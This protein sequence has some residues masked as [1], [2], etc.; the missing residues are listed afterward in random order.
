MFIIKKL[1]SAVLYI[2]KTLCFAV[3]GMLS[4]PNTIKKVGI[5]LSCSGALWIISDVFSLHMAHKPILGWLLRWI[6]IPLSLLL[7]IFRHGEVITR[8]KIKRFFEQKGFRG[9]DRKIPKYI[10]TTIL[11]RYLVKIRFKSRIPFDKWEHIVSDLEVFYKKRILKIKN[12]QE[13]MTDM[14]IY[15]IEENLPDFIEW[16]DSFMVDGRK[17]AIGEGYEGKAVWDAASLAHGICAGATG[18]GKTALLRCI[19]HQ[20]IKKKYNVTVFDFKGGGDFTESEREYQKYKDLEKGYGSF[21]ISEPKEA[22]DILLCLLVEVRGRLQYF[23]QAGA[24][25]VEE[26]NALGGLRFI[27]WLLIIDEAAEVLD[28][29]PKN[30]EE[31]D[32]YCEIDQILKTLARISRAAGVHI[33]MGIIRPSTDIIDGQIKNNLLWRACSYFADEA[34][35][36][37]VLGNDKATKLPSNVKGRFVIGD[38]E[39]QAYYLPIPKAE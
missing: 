22:R 16:D 7:L 8:H 11:N 1:S 38:D 23:K 27:P 3:K 10:L 37:L 28:V 14:D 6:W 24:S 18:G 20:A 35:S 5:V 30:K 31:K 26:F 32:L 36:R 29:K 2:V 9:Y 19:I 33:L 12:S 39:V 13:D 15:V 21:I 34:A 17:F 25:N 4:R